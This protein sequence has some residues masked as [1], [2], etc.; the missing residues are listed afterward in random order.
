MDC[1]EEIGRDRS[2][3]SKTGRERRLRERKHKGARKDYDCE[4]KSGKVLD[5][6]K[7]SERIVNK[8]H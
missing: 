3:G 5:K 4:A 1:L 6:R 7:Y 2:L 8:A